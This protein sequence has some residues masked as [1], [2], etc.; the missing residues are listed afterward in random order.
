LEP[1][2]EPDGQ[3]DAQVDDPANQATT[4]DLPRKIGVWAGTGGDRHMV[5]TATPSVGFGETLMTLF[6]CGGARCSAP[7]ST[8][9]V[10]EPGSAFASTAF[11][12]LD[13]PDLISVSATDEGIPR[14]SVH[15]PDSGALTL[16]ACHDVGC[17]EFTTTELLPPTGVVRMERWDNARHTGASMRM[18]PDNTPVIVYL[19]TRDGSV[20][21]IDCADPV[22]QERDTAQVLGPGWH[23]TPPALAL[24]SAGLPQ[25]AAF[26]V[27][28]QEVVYLACAD[29]R[30]ESYDR[31]VVGVYDHAPGWIDLELDGAD[32]PHL[33]WHRLG[34]EESGHDHTFE[35]V[36]CA[37][38][39]C[40]P[41]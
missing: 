13:Y 24:D 39:H 36:R 26:D 6:S 34:D 32:R 27:L 9:L 12:R 16:Y 30:C 41:G 23:R 19:D 5:V 1:E 3:W 38:A 21:L 18:R 4:L 17:T 33:V 14:V 40:A 28:T 15:H 35:L 11:P 10:R 8:L 2:V 29:Q 25:I 20:Q 31:T 37:D 7:A 22:C